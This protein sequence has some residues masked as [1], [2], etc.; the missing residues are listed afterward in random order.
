M[1]NL[2]QIAL[3]SLSYAG[4][5]KECLPEYNT[6]PPALLPYMNMASSGLYNRANV[7]NCPSTNGKPDQPFAGAHEL[8]AIGGAYTWNGGYQAYGYNAHVQGGFW[9]SIGFGITT[10]AEAKQPPEKIFWA[11]DAYA[12]RVDFS[13]VFLVGY[14][15]GGS[16]I[17]TYA[18]PMT[19]PG[20]KGW[21]AC[22]LD[23]H[24]SWIDAQTF[25][26]WFNGGSQPGLPW[27]WY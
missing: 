24:V 8:M 15:H 20:A 2:R 18:S 13:F 11:M 4:E 21:N 1:S 22:F 10:L 27:S 7:F 25:C 26:D 12:F 16:G 14:R 9:P 19:M 3:A 23:G 6:I 17:A 5:H